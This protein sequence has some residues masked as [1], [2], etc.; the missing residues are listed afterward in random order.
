[1]ARIVV[2]SDTHAREWGELPP[3]LRHAITAADIVVH[4][5]DYTGRR[6]LEALREYARNFV[7]VYGNVDGSA[8]R[9]QLPPRVVFEVEGRKI[10][11]T[12][13]EWGGPPF[14]PEELLPDFPGVDIVLFG[15]LHERINSKIDDTLFLNPGP[16]YGSFLSPP[17]YGEIII[18]GGRVRS[19]IKLVQ[20]E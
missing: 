14:A 12:H 8:I 20:P 17:S 16:G 9:S 2:L 10:G 15:H 11:V 3:K 13:P 19:E 7:G 6:V 18:E 1:M 5:G 4:C